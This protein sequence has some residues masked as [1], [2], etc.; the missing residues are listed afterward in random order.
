MVDL[1]VSSTEAIADWIETSVLVSSSGHLGRDRLDD[2]AA[3]EVGASAMKV[4]MAIDTMAKRA[5]V[6]G[7]SYPFRVSD[8]A[9]L[10]QKSVHADRYSALLFLTP[11]SVARQ[12]VRAQETAAMGNLLEEIAEAAL[13]NFWGLGG[14]ALSF[15][16]PS[17]HGRP[18][19]FDQAVLW[20]AGK[21]GLEAGRGY[22]P[23]RRKDGG[24]DVVAW[25]QFADRRP[26]FPL[27]LAQCTIQA[28]AFTKTTDIDL[29]LWASWL[30]M[31]S[32]PLSLL[33]IP[34]TIRSAGPDWRQLTT[35]VMV[36][37]RIRLMELLSR[38]SEDREVRWATETA[39]ALRVHLKAGEL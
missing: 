29:R 9:V 4:A 18:E 28:E 37:D 32:D 26:G 8:L 27:A 35:V 10:R 31:D 17:K 36:L 15:G 16:Y 5:K 6:L 7:D 38:G 23:P 34:G 1:E 21:I 19:P 30:A 24:V 33:V 3:S 13:A 20:L 22:R 11:G 2:L 14:I 39:S 25:R 12:T